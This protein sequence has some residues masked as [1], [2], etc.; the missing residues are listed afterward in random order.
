MNLIISPTR[1]SIFTYFKNKCPCSQSPGIPNPQILPMNSEYP[2]LP[3]NA[4]N[5][6]YIM[7]FCLVPLLKALLLHGWN[8]DSSPQFIKAVLP[9]IWF[10]THFI[11]LVC[12][13]SIK[14]IPCWI[15][16][17]ID[18]LCLCISFSMP[19]LFT[20]LA[21]F[22]FSSASYPQK[23]HLKI[24][25]FFFPSL[26]QMLHSLLIP[27]PNT[28]TIFMDCSPHFCSS[29]FLIYP[30]CHMVTEWLTALFSPCFAGRGSFAM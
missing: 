19:R 27:F 13:L 7:K 29:L 1:C 16:A 22:I 15:N 6:F 11:Q 2:D 21:V 26:L 25:S 14:A 8:R 4:V 17:I 5:I 23:E 18:Y 9:M 28:S 12:Y 20:F 3:S 10:L 30:L 24:P